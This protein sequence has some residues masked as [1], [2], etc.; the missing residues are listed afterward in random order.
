M[1]V[2]DEFKRGYAR[3]VE[4]GQKIQRRLNMVILIV[5]SLVWMFLIAK[6]C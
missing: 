5:F 4:K 6:T 1:I 3:G 2:G